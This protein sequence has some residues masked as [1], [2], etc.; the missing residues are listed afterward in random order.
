MPSELLV[1]YGSST[2][3]ECR[4]TQQASAF[5]AMSRLLR[6]VQAVKEWALTAED[7]LLRA[8]LAPLPEGLRLFAIARAR[9]DCDPLRKSLTDLSVAL[10]DADLDLDVMVLL[11]GTPDELRAFF[12]PDA[13]LFLSWQ[14]PRPV[15]P[16]TGR[17]MT[18]T[19]TTVQSELIDTHL[20]VIEDYVTAYFAP[21]P[22]VPPS[23]PPPTAPG[24]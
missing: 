17:S 15:R 11:D 8:Y 5:Q 23:A 22:P 19:A 2:A 4:P 10:V 21:P 18:S 14:E 9:G 7:R 1:G 3:R 20:V 12:E 24:G 6:T 13:A 16:S